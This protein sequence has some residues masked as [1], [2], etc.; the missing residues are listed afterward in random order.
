MP[1]DVVRGNLLAGSSHG[2]FKTSVSLAD[3][4]GKAKP[5]SQGTPYAFNFLYQ[6]IGPES[7]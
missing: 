2:R 7:I 1:A 4:T 6:E 5:N 3:A